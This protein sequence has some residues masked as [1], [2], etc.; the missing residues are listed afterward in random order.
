MCI[1]FFSWQINS[2]AAATYR[3]Y[4]CTAN[5]TS[6]RWFSITYCCYSSNSGICM[7]F[8][9]MARLLFFSF[10]RTL[11]AASGR[12]RWPICWCCLDR[13]PGSFD[14]EDATTLSWSSAAVS[15]WVIRSPY[16]MSCP[17]VVSLSEHCC[18]LPIG[19]KFGKYFAPCNSLET[20]TV[21]ITILKKIRGF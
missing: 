4:I 3:P 11:Y 1:I 14:V 16:A 2:A 6:S 17:S 19:L 18:A 8:H 15:E 7:P 9:C 10:T 12:R 13:G 21:C 5:S 20:R